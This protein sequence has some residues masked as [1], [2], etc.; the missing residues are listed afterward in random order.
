MM[1]HIIRG[2]NKDYIPLVTSIQGW[3]Q[4][5]YVEEFENL[6]LL[7]ESLARQMARASLNNEVQALFSRK[8][9]YIKNEKE[10]QKNLTKEESSSI[11][12]KKGRFWQTWSYKE[13]CLVKLKPTNIAETATLDES[14]D[15]ETLEKCFISNVI[16]VDAMADINFEDTGLWILIAVTT[17]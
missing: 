14:R 9:K 15:D 2:L 3:Q 7:Q 13:N 10:F 12:Q 1:R 4:K 8:K 16:L 11:K 6:L 5:P 17:W